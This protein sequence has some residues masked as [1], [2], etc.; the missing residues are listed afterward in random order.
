MEYLIHICNFL[1]FFQC[2]A[3]VKYLHKHH[4]I[5][6]DLKSENILVWEFPNPFS[7][8]QHTHN[9][10]IKVADYGISRAA[11]IAGAKGL[12]GTLGFMAPEIMK[13]SGREAY[14]DK[15]CDFLPVVL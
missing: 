8:N 4:I 1:T 13:Y 7:P 14:T 15:V 12:G 3:A 10:L 6:R 11:S 5:Y 2:S 9:V